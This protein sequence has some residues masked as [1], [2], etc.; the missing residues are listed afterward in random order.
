MVKNY[1]L[2][3]QEQTTENQF[4]QDAVEYAISR[5]LIK[6]SGSLED[7]VRRIAQSYDRICEA[8]REWATRPD[9]RGVDPQPESL[10]A[11]LSIG[12]NPHLSRPSRQRRPVGV[13]K[14][15]A[16]PRALDVS[17]EG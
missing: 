12:G 16:P 9:Q 4:G 15:S 11:N 8:Y 7:D 10:H 17:A 3:I 6:L 1:L 2:K 14:A 13:R 5:G